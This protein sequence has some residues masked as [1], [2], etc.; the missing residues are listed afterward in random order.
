MVRGKTQ[1][2]RIENAT[3]RQVTLSKRRNGLLKKAYEL[4]VLCDAEVGLIVFSPSGKLYEFASNSMQN[5]LEKY[6]IR[7]QEC[8][9]SESNKKQDPQC[10]KQE[11]ENMEKRVRILQSTQRKMLGDGLALCSIKEL[12]QLEGQVE[13]GLNHVRA[14][15]TKVLLDEIEKLKQKEHVLREEKALLHKK[16]VN[17]RGANGCTIP[18]IGLTSIERV[19]VQTQLVMRP[20]H[21][22]EMDDNFMDVDNMPLSG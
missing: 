22:T 16:S 4:S 18:S 7:S 1:M 9:T 10:L 20:P 11:I 2:K 15:K 17:L 6:E 19:E 5:L 14:T 3:S 21:A 13:R 12:N 8:G